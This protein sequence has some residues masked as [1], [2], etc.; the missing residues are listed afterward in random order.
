[1]TDT[2]AIGPK[3]LKP[4]HTLLTQIKYAIRLGLV[5]ATNVAIGS[6]RVATEQFGMK[7]LLHPMAWT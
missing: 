4:A 7:C 2:S 3:E 1:M 6:E 5:K